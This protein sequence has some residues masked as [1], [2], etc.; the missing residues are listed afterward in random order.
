MLVQLLALAVHLLSRAADRVL[1]LDPMRGINPA[2]KPER[3]LL[4]G[5]WS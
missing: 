1:G 5:R 3:D 2:T 4:M